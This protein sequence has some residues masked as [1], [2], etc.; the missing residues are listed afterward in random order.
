MKKTGSE[1]S[2][3]CP[4]CG[5]DLPSEETCRH[6]FD[7]CMA[8][9]FENPTTYGAVHHLTVICYML[10]H[11]GYSRDGWFEARHILARFVQDRVTPAEVRQENRSR[12]ESGFRTWSINKGEKLSELDG[13]LWTRT[14]ADIR[15]DNPKVYCAD[16]ILWARS[17]LTDTGPLLRKFVGS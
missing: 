8:L 12:S 14:I 2:Q 5:A 1:M 13:P 16:V 9:E 4:Q 17:V 7:R 6:R 3:I 15:F 11:N 10:Q